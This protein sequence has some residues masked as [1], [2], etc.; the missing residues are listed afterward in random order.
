M[1]TLIAFLRSIWGA[2]HS[3]FKKYHELWT[4]PI[5]F[6]IWLL[7]IQVLRWMD[8]TSGIFDAGVFQIP[9]FAIIQFLIYVAIAWAVL[10]VTFGNFR[11]YLQH[12][13]KH[14]F[15]NITPWQKLKLS[16][17]VFFFLLAILAYLARTLVAA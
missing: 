7:S 16:Y 14:D 11:R 1:K 9:I 3:F 17:S 12:Q 8:P 4:I 10:G 2:I 15:E 6:G 13:M 5:G